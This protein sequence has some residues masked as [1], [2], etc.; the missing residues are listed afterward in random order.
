MPIKLD[1]S[2]EKLH[3]G[4]INK[5]MVIEMVNYYRANRRKD[6][7]SL[8]FAHFTALE[9]LNLFADNGIINQLTNDQILKATPFG[10]KIYMASHANDAATCP[11][12]RE[13]Q[14]LNYDTTIICN[15]SFDGQ[16]W[17][18]LLADGQS[19]VSLAGAG[20]GLDKGSICPPDCPPNLD[21]S[22]LL[23][24]DVSTNP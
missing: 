11:A 8:K 2:S 10:A 18:D 16:T 17:N 15:T 21:V 4:R 6:A 22:N 20:D 13:T 3:G 5:K 7:N 19:S 9:V 14:Y 1:S 23:Q 12:G 24:T